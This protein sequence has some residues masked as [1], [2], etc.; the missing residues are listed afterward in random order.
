MSDVTQSLV[1]AATGLDDLFRERIESFTLTAGAAGSVTFYP[2]DG[3]GDPVT[4]VLAS[5]PALEAQVAELEATGL[6]GTLEVSRTAAGLSVFTW[7]E[8]KEAKAWRKRVALS[9]QHPTH[10][11]L[12]RRAGQLKLATWRLEADR[13]AV[14]EA[15]WRADGVVPDTSRSD[16][17]ALAQIARSTFYNAIDAKPADYALEEQELPFEELPYDDTDDVEPTTPEPVDEPTEMV[18]PTDV[19]EAPAAVEDPQTGPRPAVVVEGPVLEGTLVDA[20]PEGLE[21]IEAVHDEPVE[22]PSPRVTAP[23]VVV[24]A[25]PEPV[26]RPVRTRAVKSPASSSRQYRP[27]SKPRAAGRFS[28][29]AAVLDGEDVYLADGSSVPWSAAH[30][31]DLALLVQAHKLGWGGGEDRLPD[32]GQ[33]WLEPAALERLGLP[34]ELG[35][36]NTILDQDRWARAVRDA[37]REI[38]DLPFFAL[39][40]QAGWEVTTVH[41]W[42]RVWHPEL[43]K[44]GAWIVVP[45]WQTISRVA[46]TSVAADGGSLADELQV[47]TAPAPVL[48]KR[49]YEFAVA[50]G[51]AYRITPA[52]TGLDLIDHTRPP[53]RDKFDDRGAGRNRIAL[54]RGV[55]AEVPGFLRATDDTRFA[56]L[57]ADFSW[58]RAW[59]SLSDQERSRRFVVAFDR[60]RSYLSPWSSISLGVEG[61]VHH[62][63][64]VAWNGK[65]EPGYWLVDALQ[66]GEWPWWLPDL[67]KSAGAHVEDGRMW[68]TTHTLR[69]MDMVGITPVVHEAYTWDVTARYLESA[70]KQLR[71]ALEVAT[72]PA[73]VATI[74][75]T[76]TSTVGKLGQRDHA[77]HFHLWRPDWRHHIIAATRTAILRGLIGAQERSGAIPLV[78]DR[79]TVMYAVDSDV[80]AEAWPGDEKKLGV[81]IGA[82]KPAY[83][84]DLATWGPQHLP[85]K[86]MTGR[87]RYNRAVDDMTTWPAR[88]QEDA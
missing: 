78:V 47:R 38:E 70:A 15:I 32:L 11:E 35:V 62:T 19:A 21:V 75:N 24:E 29:P 80:V 84:A 71:Q 51:V 82:W 65:E 50:M 85:G 43:L 54:V 36:D 14:T 73:V 34:V 61:L 16:L 31:G 40:E 83:I 25:S 79:D 49:L 20:L 58:W 55:A 59:D 13:V 46:L 63:E 60:G 10:A 88:E 2:A 1:D 26:V 17:L 33:V 28:A 87:F 5:S 3:C 53:R 7:S 86:G 18:E 67:G 23:V 45:S 6:L 37:F 77:T 69:Q 12:L 64:N 42:T 57:E 4:A 9:L 41:A 30:V 44:A 8:V 56:N 76:Y 39:A 48:V 68:V 52:A 22:Q 66:A 27:G 74:K 81:G 72:D